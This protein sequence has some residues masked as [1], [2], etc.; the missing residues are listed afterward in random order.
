MH[1]EDRTRVP[2]YHPGKEALEALRLLHL[3]KKDLV[4]IMAG[5]KHLTEGM[6]RKNL[7]YCYLSERG[8]YGVRGQDLY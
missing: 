6:R 4:D 8:R 1:L 5:F 3:E 7:T 2:L